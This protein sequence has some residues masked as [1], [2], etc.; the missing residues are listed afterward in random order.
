[1]WRAGAGGRTVRVVELER[2]SGRSTLS[3]LDNAL[4]IVAVVVAGIIALSLLGWIIGVVTGV[5]W[6]LLKV[7]VVGLI[8]GLIVR[9]VAGRR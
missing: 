3:K 8:I 6:F 5:V 9:A 1:M 7:A 2:R 4:L